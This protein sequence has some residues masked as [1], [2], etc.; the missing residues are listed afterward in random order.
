[1]TAPTKPEPR[2]ELT[3]VMRR[4]GAEPPETR[5]LKGLLDQT[6][7]GIHRW[8]EAQVAELLEDA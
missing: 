5:K 4:G 6:Y 8:L 1:M 7:P 3:V 2:L